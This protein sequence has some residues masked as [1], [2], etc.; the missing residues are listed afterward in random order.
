MLTKASTKSIYTT[1]KGQPTSYFAL[2]ITKKTILNLHKYTP[3]HLQFHLH[4]HLYPN[5]YVILPCISQCTSNGW[6]YLGNTN[7]GVCAFT[8]GQFEIWKWISITRS[9]MGH[10]PLGHGV[11]FVFQFLMCDLYF[12]FSCFLFLYNFTLTCI[13]GGKPTLKKQYYFKYKGGLWP[14]PRTR[15][16]KKW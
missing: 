9:W 15:G 2:V 7:S 11:T 10:F 8:N 14:F 12:L 3:P 16:Q 13:V 6:L 5:Q 1:F 4:P